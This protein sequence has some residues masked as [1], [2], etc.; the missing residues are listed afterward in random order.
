MDKNRVSTSVKRTLYARYPTLDQQVIQFINFARSERLP[1]S[2]RLIQ[3]QAKLAAEN[4]DMTTVKASA[5]WLIRFLRCLSVQTSFKLRGKGNSFIPVG[6][7]DY[8]SSLLEIMAQ[9]SARNIFN[10]H[11]SGLYK[12]IGP[13]RTYLTGC[14]N[15]RETLGTSLIKHKDRMTIVLACNVHGF[16]NLQPTY[17]RIAKNLHCFRTGM[18]EDQTKRYASQKKWGDGFIGIL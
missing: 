7:A 16:H 18:Y 17:I 1:V 11:E 12:R 13:R 6:H 8:M 14:E 15:S 5:G 10:I 4:L 2:M 3:A 9:Y